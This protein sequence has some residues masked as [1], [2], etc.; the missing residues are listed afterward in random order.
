M[1]DLV[2]D[3]P[4]QDSLPSTLSRSDPDW[5]FV[6]NVASSHFGTWLEV[7]VSVLGFEDTSLPPHNVRYDTIYTPLSED[8]DRSVEFYPGGHTSPVP[9]DAA[10]DA[11]RAQDYLLGCRA[12]VVTS[13]E[14]SAGTSYSVGPSYQ[15]TNPQF[16]TAD[17]LDFQF[18]DVRTRAS[19]GYDTTDT[20]DITTSQAMVQVADFSTFP[21]G[22]LS[23]TTRFTSAD[24]IKSAWSPTTTL[25]N[26]FA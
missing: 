21:A 7:G 23:F 25:R 2:L 14:F 11:L 5:D 1:T 6:S 19:N 12:P 8:I 20:L 17:G 4:T 26:E 15:V 9:S 24:G 3:N 18:F 16:I 22:V 10:R 13:V